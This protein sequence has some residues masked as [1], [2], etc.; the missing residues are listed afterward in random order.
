MTTF[1]L[2][3]SKAIERAQKDAE[4][5]VKKAAIGVF[6]SVIDKSP[7][8]TG[9]FRANWNISFSAP[10]ESVSEDTD[11]TGAESKGRVYKAMSG[12]KLKDQ[13]IYLTNSLPYAMRLEEGWS[14]Q[15]PQG[16]VRLS[17]MEFNA[18]MVNQQISAMSAKAGV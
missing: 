9:R 16:M 1:A 3:L 13:S 11:K 4:L 17:V 18:G 2:D 8:D 7:V 10:D 6:S 15:A 12:Y 14:G 5:I